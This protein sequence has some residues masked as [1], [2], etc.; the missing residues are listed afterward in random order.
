MVNALP[1]VSAPLAAGAAQASDLLRLIPLFPLIGAAIHGLSL[2]LLRRPIPRAGV[3]LVSCGSVILSF[4]ASVLAIS[5]LLSHPPE[6]RVL[7]DELYTW[8]GAGSFHAEASAA[9]RS[10]SVTPP[11]LERSGCRIVIAPSS[12]T[13][14]NSNRV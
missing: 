10:A 3:I 12:I 5:E 6:A 2:G 8:I 13:R 9:T 14:L 11:V 1:D 4:L 7:V